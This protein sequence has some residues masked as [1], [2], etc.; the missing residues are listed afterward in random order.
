MLHA[1]WFGALAFLLVTALPAPARSGPPV[2][3]IRDSVVDRRAL[4]IK[5]GYGQAINGKSFQQDALVSHG[6]WQYLGYYDARRHVCVARRKLPAGKWEILRLDDY[7]FGSN[8]AHNSISMGICPKDGTIHLAFDHHCHPLNYR[9][10]RKGVAT[11]PEEIDWTTELFG[12]VVDELEKGRRIRVTYPRFWQTP[13][14]GLQFCY[15]RGGSGNGHRMLVDY[16]PAEGTWRDTRQIDSR[17]GRY[18]GSRSR[19]SYPNGYTYGPN[20]RLHTTWVWREGGGTP[21]HDLVYIYSD[22]RG[23]TWRNNTGEKL[24]RPARVDSPGVTVVRISEK[25]GLMNTHGQA[26]DSEGRVHVVMWHC[27]DQSLAAIGARPGQS[28]WGPGKA[29][30]YHHYW[31]GTDGEWHHTELPWRSGG[32]PKVFI[33]KADNAY[34]IYNGGH[35]LKVASATAASK[36]ND[37]EVVHVEEGPFVNEMIGDPYRWRQ[38]NVLS[39][40]AQTWP[41]KPHAPTPLRVL[42]FRPSAETTRPTQEQD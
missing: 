26:V 2:Q 17:K 28:R 31:R 38:E 12:P 6:G 33:D 16:D 4:T 19:C 35:D 24:D 9:V 13:D 32:R 21:N 39:I 23:R 10:S 11:R 1:T 41:D 34:L 27:S 22:D 15:R 18:H 37:W 20:G 40:L 3:K 42:D 25:Y 30:R 14:G 29:R 5:G 36:W 7:H 8:D